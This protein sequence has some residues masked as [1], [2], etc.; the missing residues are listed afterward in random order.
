MLPGSD[1]HAGKNT[2]KVF[3]I[4]SRRIFEGEKF[5]DDIGK[6]CQSKI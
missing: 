3:S 4:R 6:V 1:S 5:A 2:T